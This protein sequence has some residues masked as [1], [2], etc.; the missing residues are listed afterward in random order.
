MTHLTAKSFLAACIGLGSAVTP[1]AL[2][3]R[4]AVAQ[5]LYPDAVRAALVSG[6][7][8]RQIGVSDDGR[9]VV[10]I[11][12]GQARYLDAYDSDTFTSD[13]TVNVVDLACDDPVAVFVGRSGSD[14]VVQIPCSDGTVERFALTVTTDPEATQAFEPLPGEDGATTVVPV[15]NLTDITAAAAG[16]SQLYVVGTDAG[17]E[18]YSVSSTRIYALSIDQAGD[19]PAVSYTSFSNTTSIKAMA[20]REA[21]G[22]LVA[23]S[24]SGD[25]F[26]LKEGYVA[27]QSIITCNEYEG[28]SPKQLLL[29]TDT[30]AVVLGSESV[31][32]MADFDASLPVSCEPYDWGVEDPVAMARL[33]TGGD[34]S[35]VDYLYLLGTFD[36]GDIGVF[37][38]PTTASD[39]TPIQVLSERDAPE[40]SDV[41]AASA[42][43]R[44]YLGTAE[45]LSVLTA[46]PWL[47]VTVAADEPVL[48]TEGQTTVTFSV[49]SDED[50]ADCFDV[51]D[52]EPF[53][54]NACQDNLGTD[55]PTAGGTV[56]IT[57]QDLADL[58]DAGLN[59]IF[60][61]G[62]DADGNLGWT[63]FR[64][65]YVARP[66]KLEVALAFGD[67]KLHLYMERLDNEAVDDVQLLMKEG[68]TEADAMFTLPDDPDSLPEGFDTTSPVI[69]VEDPPYEYPVGS[70]PMSI[71]YVDTG[72]PGW[73]ELSA[74]ELEYTLYPLNNDAWYCVSLRPM[75]GAVA[76]DAWSD[77]VCEKVQATLGAASVADAPGF[78]LYSPG[79]CTTGAPPAGRRGGPWGAVLLPAAWIALRRRHVSSS[80]GA[81]REKPV[82][83]SI[84]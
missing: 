52:T 83:R 20:V 17:Q 49:T 34:G 68:A 23:I 5:T 6:T 18:G 71:G 45:G 30:L 21:Y 42:L 63:S 82:R 67:Q 2:G 3:P 62:K 70:W 19:E 84:A 22:D 16:S 55:L 48:M 9:V 57:D 59:Q 51:G 36:G 11:E 78:C 8:A 24:S 60:I 46:G 80:P 75:A 33:T 58:V 41:I 72:D 26:V 12:P 15:G 29:I 50:V 43:A 25:L 76:G 1:W 39:N 66:G 28:T 53:S 81:Q 56:V 7:P 73:T 32:Y 35:A 47:D 44:V 69:V 61:Y 79:T 27:S 31:V 77:V 37:S 38:T 14:Y 74:T 10:D 64:V 65:Y 54:G 40:S 13:D 4:S